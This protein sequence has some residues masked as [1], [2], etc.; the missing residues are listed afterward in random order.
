MKLDIHDLVEN[1][2]G[3]LLLTSIVCV[4]TYIILSTTLA[5][6]NLI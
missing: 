5:I 6:I 2:M 1:A 4:L 3:I